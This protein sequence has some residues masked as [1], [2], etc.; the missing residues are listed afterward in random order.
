MLPLTAGGTPDYLFAS[1]RAN[2]CNPAGVDCIY[3]SE[4]ELTA[5]KEY[6]RRLG[7]GAGAL[8]PLGTFF[9]EVEL[10]RVLDL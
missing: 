8:Q 10:A 3:L 1:G 7:R 6:G 5:R 9:A 2:R 4:G